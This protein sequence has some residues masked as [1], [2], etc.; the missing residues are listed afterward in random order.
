MNSLFDKI[1]IGNICCENRILRSATWEGISD[2]K[3]FMCQK[4]YD[5]YEELAKNNVGLISTGYARILESDCPNA[6][7][8]GIYDDCFIP[9]YKKLTDIVHKYKS[10]I[11]MQIAYGG[12]KTTYK[13]G[14][15][16]IYCPSGIPET[17]TGTQGK[18]MTVDEIKLVVKA[19]GEAAKRVKES[20]FD[21]V[22][23]H[24]GHNYLLNQFLSPYY[25]RRT[26]EYGGSFENRIRAVLECYDEVRNA[27]GSD[28]TVMIKVTCT[29]FVEV[30]FTFEDC[31]KLCK[32]LEQKGI[33]GIEISGNIHGKAEKMIGE[34]FEGKTILKE[35][36]FLE[37]GKVI[38]EELNIPVY[39]T[40]GFRNPENMNKILSETKVSGFGLSRPFMTE[41]N[42]VNR[43]I[44]GD[45]HT[46]K[47]VHCS[48]CRTLDGNYCTVFNF[49]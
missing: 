46:A 12:S 19:H 15:R 11:M 9:Q 43:W 33:D 36:Y 29:D 5:I 23:I 14:E 49:N 27:V 37:Y 42:I 45:L 22:E 26:D 25:N 4:Q 32:I 18:E 44:N 48:K 35:G 13:V 21:A 39:V 28:F 17:S 38:A 47:C 34:I 2:E 41:P 31:I 30:G 20:G 7:M 6:G 24:A 16:V 8:M 40:G 1:N 3:G 10:K